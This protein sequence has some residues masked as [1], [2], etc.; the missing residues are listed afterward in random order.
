MK[1]TLTTATGR[2]SC[3]LCGERIEKGLDCAKIKSYS[4]M[5][6][7]YIHYGVRCKG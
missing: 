2:A 1:A 5:D 4:A 6:G 7:G 3:V